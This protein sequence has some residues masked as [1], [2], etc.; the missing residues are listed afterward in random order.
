MERTIPYSIDTECGALGSL[1]ID[2]EAM[3]LVADWLHPED[4]YRDSYRLIYESMMRLSM[5]H[6][7]ANFIML[8]DLLEGVDV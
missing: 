5:R 8:Y 6:E 3:P 4:F 1:I 7:T 2:P